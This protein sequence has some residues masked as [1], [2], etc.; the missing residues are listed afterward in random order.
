MHEAGAE[1]VDADAGLRHCS[2]IG[3]A[4]RTLRLAPGRERPA[5][6]LAALADDV[7][8]ALDQQLLQAGEVPVKVLALAPAPGL[9]PLE[10]DAGLGQ[11]PLGDLDVGE[12]LGEQDSIAAASSTGSSATRS[13]F[14]SY[15]LRSRSPYVRGLAAC[16]ASADSLA[17]S[18]QARRAAPLPG[19][20]HANCANCLRYA[21]AWRERA[22]GRL[23]VVQMHL[24][25][26][27]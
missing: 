9:Q 24:R 14:S 7:Q 16:L 25:V 11:Q 17:W 5:D 18:F 19:C 8:A 13:R 21:A 1:E 10:R 22:L 20:S 26:A 3:D 23:D 27:G 2:Q 12:G 4:E 15:C 6:Q